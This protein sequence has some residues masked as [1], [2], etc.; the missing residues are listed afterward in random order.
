MAS[1]DK[2]RATFTLLNQHH[3]TLHTVQVP[4]S[5]RVPHSA[6]SFQAFSA[7]SRVVTPLAQ[8]GGVQNVCGRNQAFGTTGS[9]QLRVSADCSNTGSSR[10]KKKTPKLVPESAC[11]PCPACGRPFCRLYVWGCDPCR[12]VPLRAPTHGDLPPYSIHSDQDDH[13]NHVS[14]TQTKFAAKWYA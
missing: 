8:H 2:N 1:P 13:K 12:N 5:H 3:G 9:T 14:Q 11:W 7:T 6:T 4:A 10:K